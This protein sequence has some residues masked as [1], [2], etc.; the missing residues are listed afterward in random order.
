ME[1]E[2][3]KEWLKTNNPD[4]YE[5]LINQGNSMLCTVCLCNM[6]CSYIEY[7]WRKSLLEIVKSGHSVG[8]GS[9][10]H[11]LLIFFLCI[12]P[13]SDEQSIFFFPL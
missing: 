10:S 7:S 4:V 1:Y 8:H 11:W 3:C 13:A 2:K 12:N 9:D 5:A 6:T